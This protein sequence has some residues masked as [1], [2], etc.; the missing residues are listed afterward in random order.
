M[1]EYLI[2]QYEANLFVQKLKGLC[3]SQIYSDNLQQLNIGIGPLF[4][5]SNLVAG[6]NGFCEDKRIV[7]QFLLSA[8]SLIR[9]NGTHDIVYKSNIN[10]SIILSDIE[11]IIKNRL[12]SNVYLKEDNSLV[13]VL[14]NGIDNLTLSSEWNLS[15][16]ETEEELLKITRDSQLKIAHFRRRWSRNHAR[17][18][19]KWHSIKA[20]GDDGND[21][22]NRHDAYREHITTLEG[23]TL[24]Y[25]A[26]SLDM[27]L[28]DIGFSRTDTPSNYSS[29]VISPQEFSLH[30]MCAL[31]IV[32][33]NNNRTT[34]Y[35]DC[36][37]GQFEG[38]ILR[39]IGTKVLGASLGEDNSLIIFFNDCFFEIVPADDGEESWRLFET[40]KDCPHLVVAD[41][42][43]LLT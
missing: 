34:Y 18:R 8:I 32:E 19:D 26:K 39:F 9:L 27:N 29:S 14:D 13:I 15:Q 28:F 42:W 11:N 16:P 40:D 35:G 31:S 3:I 23:T 21:E 30:I 1:L 37:K 38:D 2:S 33:H 36:E 17:C 43:I 6:Q 22:I 24:S 20:Q 12:I 7:P 5:L 41:D 25:A 4:V 10:N